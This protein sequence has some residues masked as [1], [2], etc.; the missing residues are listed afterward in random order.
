MTVRTIAS[1]RMEIVEAMLLDG[2]PLSYAARFLAKDA[3]RIAILP[4]IDRMKVVGIIHIP[5]A[6]AGMMLSGEAPLRAVAY[7]LAIIYALAIATVAASGTVVYGALFLSAK[8]GK[9]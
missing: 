9:I 8:R 4:N 1:D 5:G 6:M 2:A 3:L 7:Q